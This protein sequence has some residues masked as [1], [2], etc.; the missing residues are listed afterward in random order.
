M[1]SEIL[2]DAGP[3]RRFPDG[4]TIDKAAQQD[5]YGGNIMQADWENTHAADNRRLI[6]VVEDE[7]I[8]RDILGAILA[9]DYEVIFAED[10]EQ[11]LRAVEENSGI[12]SLVLLDLIMPN[13][14]GLP[15][16]IT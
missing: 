15:I 14:P 10:G 4:S 7:A 3:H 16:S 13:M 12:L 11:A 2:S 6:L 8:N 5:A 9:Q 1:V